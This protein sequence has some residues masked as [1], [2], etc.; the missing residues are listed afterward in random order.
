MNVLKL[1]W[2]KILGICLF[3]SGIIFIYLVYN[4]DNLI[5]HEPVKLGTKALLGII[6]GCI[7]AI[8]GIRIYRRK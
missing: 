5:R 1:Y 6:A 3:I 8:N 7:A 2:N 4:F